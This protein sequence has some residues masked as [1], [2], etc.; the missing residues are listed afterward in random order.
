MPAEA[1]D[2]RLKLPREEQEEM[3]PPTAD[4]VE[5]VCSLLPSAYRLPLLW[6]DSSGAR[7]SSVEATLVG[8]YDEA[9]RRVR[10]RKAT[11]KNRAA[12]WVDVLADAVE[13]TLPPRDDRDLSAPLFR[14]A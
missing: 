3:Q 7:L 14:R 11:T 12:L 1:R 10:L 13:A 6:L 4:H 5:T 8:D 9:R 2:R